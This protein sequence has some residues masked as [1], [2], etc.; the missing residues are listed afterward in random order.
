MSDTIFKSGDKRIISGFET[1]NNNFIFFMRIWLYINSIWSINKN[2]FV[3]V[4][5]FENNIEALE[6]FKPIFDGYNINIIEFGFI[7]LSVQYNGEGRHTFANQV[8]D[9]SLSVG[10]R[11]EH[12]GFVRLKLYFIGNQSIILL[13]GHCR[14]QIGN[15]VISSLPHIDHQ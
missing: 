11:E 1:R 3:I 15:F 6:F 9:H 8:V 10:Q 5:H 4:F 7:S 14:G 12:L 2:G 13:K